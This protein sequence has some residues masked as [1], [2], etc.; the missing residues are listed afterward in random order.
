MKRDAEAGF[1]K[2]GV[3][4]ETVNIFAQEVNKLMKKG[5]KIKFHFAGH[6]TGAVLFGYLLK[7]M[8]NHNIQF[9]TVSLLAPACNIDLFSEA[10]LPVLEGKTKIKINDF[11]VYNLRD[12]LERKDVVGS[13]LVYRKSLLYL[14]SNSFE[15]SKGST[16]VWQSEKPLLGMEKFEDDFNKL[17]KDID[18]VYSNGTTS[19]E[20]K[21]LTHGGF[22]NDP[23]TMNDIL[24]PVLK[25]Q[26]VKYKFS[27]DNLKY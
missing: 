6:S 10:H 4:T 20:T 11:R 14:V 5:R 1:L 26:R 2:Q 16:T 13:S 25:V 7:G 19:K 12:R 22:D 3:G 18:F 21:S 15:K 27:D 17:N 9:E 8:K 24:K 23:Q